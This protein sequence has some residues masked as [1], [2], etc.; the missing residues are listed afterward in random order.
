MGNPEQG[1]HIPQSEQKIGLNNLED[2]LDAYEGVKNVYTKFIEK[3]KNQ[4]GPKNPEEIKYLQ[5]ASEFITKY[6]EAQQKLI[7]RQS[8][9]INDLQDQKHGGTQEVRPL[10]DDQKY[11]EIKQ[12]RADTIKSWSPNDQRIYRL[13]DLKRRMDD[14]DTIAGVTFEDFQAVS[15]LSGDDLSRY[16]ILQTELESIK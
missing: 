5:Q 12:R 2:N 9:R 6:N 8:S 4:G 14:G 11:A 10:A 1:G 15:E 13:G 7:D 16:E 3:M